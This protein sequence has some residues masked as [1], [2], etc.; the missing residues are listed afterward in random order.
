M[1]KPSKV[2]AKQIPLPDVPQPVM[3]RPRNGRKLFTAFID[4]SL[5][6][7]IDAL[8]KQQDLSRGQVL[9]L[10]LTFAKAELNS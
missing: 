10:L 6:D 7:D 3:G 4:V 9:E 2:Y 5:I 1:K 8:A